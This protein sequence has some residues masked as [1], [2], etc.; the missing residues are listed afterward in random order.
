MYLTSELK[1]YYQADFQAVLNFE[2]TD[3]WKLD[4]GLASSLTS[5]NSQQGIQTLY[6]RFHSKI[7]IEESIS[8]LRLAYHQDWKSA[9]QQICIQLIQELDGR[10]AE[11]IVEESVPMP[12]KV[13]EGEEAPIGCLNN[14]DYFAVAHYYIAIRSDRLEYHKRF[15]TLLEERLTTIK[16]G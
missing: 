1:A 10:E 12:N 4:T 16:V 5:I 14:P 9:V 13:F 2:G 6:S 15:W 3:Y 11:V 7:G 8:Y